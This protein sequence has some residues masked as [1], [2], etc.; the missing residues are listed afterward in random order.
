MTPEED[1]PEH[2]EDGLQDIPKRTP[3]TKR[4]DDMETPPGKSR[5]SLPKRIWQD[6]TYNFLTAVGT[7]L[8]IASNWEIHDDP[9]GTMLSAV[10]TASQFRNMLPS[11][12]SASSRR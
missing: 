3:D 2:A 11:A 12:S 4:R 10:I 5:K 1:D 8:A 6:G 7:V 9:A